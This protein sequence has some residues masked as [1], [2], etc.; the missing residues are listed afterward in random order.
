MYYF[1]WLCV[2]YFCEPLYSC[3]I[4]NPDAENIEKRFFG[5]ISSKDDGD[6]RDDATYYSLHNSRYMIHHLCMIHN[7]ARIR[8]RAIL[9]FAWL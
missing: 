6:T 4:G 5:G 1:A 9:V 2:S 8:K 3:R 7:H